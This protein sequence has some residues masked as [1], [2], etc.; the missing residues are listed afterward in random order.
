MCAVW[1]ADTTTEKKQHTFRAPLSDSLTQGTWRRHA[2]SGIMG[3]AETIGERWNR[4]KAFL[5]MAVNYSLSS[6]ILAWSWKG[7]PHSKL[8]LVRSEKTPNPQPHS[9]SVLP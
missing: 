8:K 1:G 2:V 9:H 7:L 6:C 4:A 5:A 3:E